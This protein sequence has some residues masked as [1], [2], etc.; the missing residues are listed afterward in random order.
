VR[1]VRRGVNEDV[2]MPFLILGMSLSY[3]MFGWM[4]KVVP[5]FFVWLNEQ[6]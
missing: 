6:E 3:L 4:D 5:I 2:M 1:L